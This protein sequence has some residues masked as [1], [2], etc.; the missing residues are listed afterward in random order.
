MRPIVGVLTN[1]NS[2]KNRR[3]PQRR[4]DLERAVGA[5]GIVRETCDVDSLPRV[6]EEFLDAGCRWWVCDGGDGTL[7]W[8][9]SVG[10]ELVRA[11]RAAGVMVDWPGIVPGNGGSIDFVAHKVGIRG[12]AAQLVRVLV[13]R[14][15][16][17]VPLDTVSIDTL[18][19]QG[20][21]ADGSGIDH[22]GFASAVGGIAQRFFDKLYERKPVDAWSIARVIG[23]S[24]A[25]AFA[26]HTPGLGQLL[27]AELRDY[28]EAVFEPTLAHV[29][30]DGRALPFESFASLQVGAIDISLGGVVR[31]FRHAQAPGVL[32]AQAISTSP[33]GIVANL[34]NIVLGTP[35]W[36][37]QVFDGTAQSMQVRAKGGSTLD[38][39]IDG[40]LFRGFAALDIARGPS[41]DVP[42]LHAA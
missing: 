10:H 42:V 16:A 8:M 1:P 33:L 3:H 7:H 22:L 24:T 6:L 36:G 18:H 5:A 15:R 23:R 21:R 2:G 11:R 31:T 40:E 28:A 14:V 37:R 41:L 20:R 32:H 30:V 29:D 26:N 35:I 34:P 13:H 38:P 9:L 12:D 17:G 27:P 4:R 25:G 19:V 39:V